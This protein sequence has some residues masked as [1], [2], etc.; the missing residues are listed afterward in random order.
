MFRR[1]HE[2]ALISDIGGVILIGSPDMTCEKLSSYCALDPKTIRDKIWNSML[3]AKYEMGLLTRPGEAPKPRGNGHY[4]E[5]DHVFYEEVRYRLGADMTFE[6]FREA[7]NNIIGVN[8]P[9][10]DIY[11]RAMKKGH[12]V[13]LLSDTNHMHAEYFMNH[14]EWGFVR[15]YHGHV[16]SYE[17]GHLKPDLVLV[18]R[19]REKAY[20]RRKDVLVVDDNPKLIDGFRACG[21]DAH[22]YDGNDDKL[23][24]RMIERGFRI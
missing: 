18:D 19:A 12:K 7:W 9:V 10:V 21:I 17:E 11:A 16:F 24:E 3:F 22:L 15:N 1:R 13:V 2:P 6:Q 4:E 14:P 23:A 8:P 5:M 20:A